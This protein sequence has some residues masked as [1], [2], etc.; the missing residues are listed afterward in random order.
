MRLRSRGDFDRVYQRGAK[1][2]NRQLVAWILPLAEPGPPRLGLSVSRK[3]GG[4]PTRNRVKRCLREAFRQLA[5]GM[6]PIELV[7]LARPQS[8]PL[9]LASARSSLEHIL[10]LHRRGGRPGQSSGRRGGR[11]GRRDSPRRAP[12]GDGAADHGPAQPPAPVRDT[13]PGAPARQDTPPTPPR[14][15][16]AR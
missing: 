5:P 2:V 13:E 8:P 9:D 14:D 1:Q 4:A 7:L 6:P 10:R 3:V 12:A 16:E 15:G 11:S